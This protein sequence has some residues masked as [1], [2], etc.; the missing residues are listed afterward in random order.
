[1]DQQ[2]LEELQSRLLDEQRR[3]REELGRMGTQ[4]ETAADN[5]PAKFPEFGQ[6]EDENAQEV[7]TY[8]NR[9]SIE[10][11]LESELADVDAALARI[12]DGTFGTCEVCGQPIAEER[13][14]ANP[15]ARTCTAHGA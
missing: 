9:L 4:S 13:L 1:M 5:F 2:L 6:E 7:D 3:L 15:A 12:A 14:H 10:R 8:Q 11:D